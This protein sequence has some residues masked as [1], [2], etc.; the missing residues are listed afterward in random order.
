MI[1]TG[2]GR[3]LGAIAL[4]A[5]VLLALLALA[6]A[7]PAASRGN[8]VEVRMPAPRSDEVVLTRLEAQM[9]A[10]YGAMGPLSVQRVSRVPRGISIAAVRARQR[11]GT[12]IVRLVAVRSSGSAR[13]GGMRVRLRIGSSRMTF[14]RAL[15]STVPINPATSVRGT[16]DCRTINGEAGRWTPVPGLAGISLEGLRFGARTAVAAA[17]E[18]ACRRTITTVGGSERFLATVDQGF[19]DRDEGGVVEGFYATWARDAAGNARI[20]VYVRGRRGGEGDVTVATTTQAYELGD[21]T[22]I[23]RVDT[24]V[25]GEGEYAFVV[26]WRQPDGTYRESESTLRIPG[27]GQKGNDPPEPY[28]AGGLCG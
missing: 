28:A 8:V 4:S 23:A 18:I 3:P 12:V 26:R 7:A 17:M 11:G 9:R 20:C 25:A 1:Q 6:P 24:A 27:G 2:H 21:D 13:F 16:R 5:F 15:T 14:R 22:G 10:R 19:V